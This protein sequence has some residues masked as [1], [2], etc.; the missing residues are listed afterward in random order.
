MLHG[1]QKRNAMTSQ[2][3]NVCTVT[4]I[5]HIK[6]YLSMQANCESSR[7]SNMLQKDQ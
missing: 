6:Q 7:K 4:A 5:S 1:K 3:M 2:G